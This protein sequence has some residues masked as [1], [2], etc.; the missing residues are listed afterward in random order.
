MAILSYPTICFTGDL[1][2]ERRSA[3]VFSPRDHLPAAGKTLK[4][5]AKQMWAEMKG[6]I[7]W[8]YPVDRFRKF[9]PVQRNSLK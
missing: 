2:E 9:F 3:Q 7:L 6:L 1:R 4:T 5:W 8:E